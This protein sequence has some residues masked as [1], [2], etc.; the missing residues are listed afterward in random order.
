MGLRSSQL[1]VASRR[2]CGQELIGLRPFQP[3]CS[4]DDPVMTS[5]VHPTVAQFQVENHVGRS[6]RRSLVQ[7][8]PLDLESGPIELT[9]GTITLG[10]SSECTILIADE[11]VSRQHAVIR[12]YDGET[13]ITDLGS[14]NGVA[15]NGVRVDEA[16][17]SSG[18]Q[19]Q[20]GTRI[21]RFLADEDIESQYHETVYSMMTRD[22]LTGIYNRR[23]LT[24]TLEREVARCKRHRRPIAVIMIDI[25]HFNEV[26]DNY[27]H[28]VGDQV[29]RE[30]ATRMENVLRRDDVL[31]RYGGEEFA[32]LI[33]ESDMEETVD[34]AERCRRAVGSSSIETSVGQIK[35]TVSIGVAAPDQEGI[36]SSTE[37]IQEAK[38][39]LAEAKTGGRDRVI[40]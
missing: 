36:G 33:V 29:L 21:Y 24:E 5:S 27:G 23:Y 13:Q 1:P 11:S 35:A 8:H 22:G 37:L 14:T 2:N 30:V 26:N 40:C 38:E 4:N 25:D 17:L 3:P 12:Q 7:L 39:R 18:D 31:A 28:I 15:V 6:T 20:L 19:V 16:R 10:R 34:V 32:L 9:G